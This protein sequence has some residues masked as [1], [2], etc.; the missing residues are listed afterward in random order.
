MALGKTQ[1]KTDPPHHRKTKRHDLQGHRDRPG[2]LPTDRGACYSCTGYSLDGCT[3]RRSVMNRATWAGILVILGLLGMLVGALDPLEGSVV[4]LPGVGLV[5]LGAFLAKRRYLKL[6]G[7]SFV[8]VAV[9]VAAML[10]KEKSCK[11]RKTN[12]M[13]RRSLALSKFC[14]ERWLRIPL[15]PPFSVS[16]TRSAQPLAAITHPAESQPQAAQAS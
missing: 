6:L 7:T 13:R 4:I 15:S 5:T 2:S 11:Y 9:G 8:L 14:S 3:G 12:Q 10:T 1:L 16:P